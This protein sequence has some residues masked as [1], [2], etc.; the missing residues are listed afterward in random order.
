MKELNTGLVISN[1]FLVIVIMSLI[2]L[3]SG[4]T[5]IIIRIMGLVMLGLLIVYIVGV[6]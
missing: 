3:F 5:L 1:I 6:E 2:D 4:G